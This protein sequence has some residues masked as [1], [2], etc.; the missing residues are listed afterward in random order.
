LAWWPSLEIIPL[1]LLLLLLLLPPVGN[2]NGNRNPGERDGRYMFCG[3]STH[4]GASTRSGLD[5]RSA[6]TF[7]IMVPMLRMGSAAGMVL[8]WGLPV[9]AV[10]PLPLLFLLQA[11]DTGQ[12]STV[13]TAE[14]VT[15][16]GMGGNG[17]APT[18]R[19]TFGV[20][21][22][23]VLRWWLSRLEAALSKSSDRFTS[24]ALEVSFFGAGGAF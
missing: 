5:R 18:T 19:G 22:P 13:Y 1:L 23:P 16:A 7:S 24:R 11:A 14:E 21:L 12:V 6:S 3:I 20:A 4:R 10:L 17:A 15:V 2:R 9:L 8:F